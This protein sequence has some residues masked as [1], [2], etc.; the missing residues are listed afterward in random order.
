MTDFKNFIADARKRSGLSQVKY[1]ALLGMPDQTYANWERGDKTPAEERQTEIV[2][3]IEELERTGTPAPEAAAGDAVEDAPVAAENPAV[4][5]SAASDEEPKMNK[6]A[7]P[8]PAAPP[9][10][11]PP[12]PAAFP[13][14]WPDSW[15]I[16]RA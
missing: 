13:K 7:E 10:P 3:K 11:V 16:R 15:G 2:A 1:A 6:P 8:A 4:S 9:A 12:A 5:I 14:A